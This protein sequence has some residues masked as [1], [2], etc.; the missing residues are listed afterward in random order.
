[1][2]RIYRGI[3][4]FFTLPLVGCLP[5][6]VPIPVPKE[7][8]SAKGR[9]SDVDVSSV[10]PGTAYVET[11]K[12][13]ADVKIDCGTSRVFWGRWNTSHMS[14]VYTYGSSRV[15]KTHNVVM[16][17][18]GSGNLT[19]K[20]VVSDKDLL[21]ALSHAVRNGALPPLSLDHDLVLNPKLFLPGNRIGEG[22]IRLTASELKFPDHRTGKVVAV[23]VTALDS[24]VSGSWPYVSSNEPSV[25]PGRLAVKINFLGKRTAGK[26]VQFGMEPNDFWTFI[27]WLNQVKGS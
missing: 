5:I 6:I 16:E 12:K 24:L 22:E 13:L 21:P 4:L 10:Q 19:L 1:M 14:E 15:R 26:N 27:R 2:Y 3:T 18:D 23:P 7:S 25:S 11:E 17:F 8:T 20:T 9:I